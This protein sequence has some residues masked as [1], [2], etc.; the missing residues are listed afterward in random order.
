MTDYLSKVGARL[1]QYGISGKAIIRFASAMPL[2]ERYPYIISALEH[3]KTQINLGF[4]WKYPPVDI[5]TFIESP[6][7]LDK[8]GV[9]YPEIMACLREANNGTYI[10]TVNTG[11]IGSGKT[12]FA[13]YSQAYQL[14]ILSCLARP[15]YEFGLDTS[16]EIMI[17]FQSISGKLSKIVDYN[18]FRSMIEGSPYFKSIFP[19]KKDVESEL[20]FPNR[21]IVRPL[22]GDSQAAIGQ[23]VVGGILDEVNFMS[24]VERSKQSDDGGVYDQAKALYNAIV[25][26]RKSRFMSKGRLFGLLNLVSSKR[27][28]GEFTDVKM[29]EARA[30]I[31]ERGRTTIYVYDKCIWD[32]KPAGS[33]SAE[34]FKVFCGDITRKPYILKP[35]DDVHLSDLHL[36][37]EIPLE[38]MSDFRRDILGS[39]RDV[40]GRA[41][42]AINP[43]F[44][45][46]EALAMAM[47]A[48]ESVISRESCDFVT[49]SLQI[50]PDKFVNPRLPRFAHVDLSISGDSTGIAIGHVAGF[51]TV[52]RN[53]TSEIMPQIVY[54]LTLE[55]KPPKAGEIEFAK[56]RS[57]FYKLRELGMNLKWVS[58][59]SFQSTDSLQIL[60]TQGFSVGVQ[61]MDTS[62]K[63]YD[64]LKSALYDG[65]VKLPEHDRLLNEMVRLE[66]DSKTGKID[67]PANS[68]KDV[69]DAVAGVA[70]GLTMQREI[71]SMFDIPSDQIPEAILN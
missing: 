64:T 44:T 25:N 39:I 66:R 69:S 60:A 16:S 50:Y 48:T 21:I 15:Q 30:E 23:N 2:A 56:I 36:I 12:T 65:R 62:P 71:W 24:V 46:T 59:D 41:T 43:Y 10:E 17:V 4:R 70:Y 3:L 11:G 14:Y 18:R 19:F 27:Y 37:A 47:G 67:H 6:E 34:R 49:T 52:T 29:A 61:S 58:Y 7:L 33:F 8:A 31:A 5:R 32:V 51:V 42:M 9:I 40:A 20:I 26:R 22:S 55:V 57:L 68:S 28:P 45:N 53:N 54:D 38:Y 13:L 1:L 63:A 35:G